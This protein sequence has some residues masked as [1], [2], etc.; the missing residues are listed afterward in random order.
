MKNIGKKSIYI[1]NISED[2]W[3]FIS[4]M[5]EKAKNFEVAE[6]AC[7]SDHE[8]LSISDEKKDF[9]VSPMTIE[10]K[11][12]EYFRIL[13]SED[14]LEIL[15]PEKHSGEI[16]RD[17]MADKKL[18]SKLVENCKG[19]KVE[20]SAYSS[21]EQFWS[22]ISELKNQGLDIETPESP[23]QQQAWTV[24]F[25]GSK[26]GIRQITQDDEDLLMPN[27]LICAG[28]FDSV[29]IA[30]S[31]Y[32][33]EGGVVIK[34]NKGHAGAGVLIFR[35]GD[36]PNSYEECEK[37]LSEIL[38]IDEYWLRFPI[39]VESLIEVGSG[40]GG[41]FP[42][43]EMKISGK[44]G[45]VDMLYY[46]GMRVSRQGVFGGMEVGDKV[47]EEK[48][49][50]KIMSS[51]FDIG[52]RYAKMGYRGYFDVD[53]I[54]GKNGQL[55]ITESNLR[56]TGGTHVYKAALKLLGD[57]F[58]DDYVILS[59]NYYPLP[60]DKTYSF[61]DIVKTLT[62]ILFNKKKKEGVLLA[63]AN[64]LSKGRLA[65]FVVGKNKSRAAKIEDEMIDRLK[66]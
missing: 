19:Y 17:L 41:G 27:G 10:P 23:T 14:K 11:F 65:Y 55:Y 15:V 5:G 63:S 52:E 60:D 2:V 20:L 61:E 30:A 16:C 59:H 26:S 36:L 4:A 42:N 64:T 9:Y 12:L 44:G 34:T 48:F 18:F 56:R 53:F 32:V 24:N 57:D 49:L 43:I 28:I 1:S 46:A 7:L 6:N 29:K 33:N 66:K 58:I 47:I 39:V 31:K 40:I 37:K 13:F 50:A 45:K 51:G 62:P 35:K 21:S 3:Q 25:L 22:L 38:K 8:L 54:A